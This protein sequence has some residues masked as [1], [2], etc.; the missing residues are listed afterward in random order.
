MA[1]A[2][3]TKTDAKADADL[4]EEKAGTKKSKSKKEPAKQTIK[5]TAGEKE[6]EEETKKPVMKKKQKTAKAI[7][8]TQAKRLV[9]PSPGKVAKKR[10]IIRAVKTMK[11]ARNIGVE[12]I[13]P[14][15]DCDD[16]FCPFHGTLSVR[17]Q[18][19]N[20]IV[21]SSKMDKTAIIQR[22]VKRKIPKYE[23][24][25]KRT[26]NYA[27][28]NPPCLNVQRGDLVK[29]MECR[30]LSKSKSFVVIEKS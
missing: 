28:H 14:E 10:K 1:G 30:P 20:G 13:P 8:K 24:F 11:E 16:P 25:E 19:I 26:H 15:K 4:E 12:V 6:S 18:I 5:K 17:G 29:I 9:K 27:V 22:E 3:K 7:D 2:K 23:R 21:V